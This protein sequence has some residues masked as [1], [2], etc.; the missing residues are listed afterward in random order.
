MHAEPGHA[1]QHLYGK[2]V[3][4]WEAERVEPRLLGYSAV[5]GMSYSSWIEA[6]GGV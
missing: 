6:G 1:S 3:P 4:Q 5:K 2:H